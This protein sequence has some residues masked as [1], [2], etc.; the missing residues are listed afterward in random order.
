MEHIVRDLYRQNAQT[1]TPAEQEQV[2]PGMADLYAL[3]GRAHTEAAMQLVDHGVTC[4]ASSGRLLFRVASSSTPDSDTSYC[5]L[6]GRFC[7]TCARQP[8]AGVGGAPCIHITA[9]L[10]AAAQSKCLV[11]EVPAEELASALFTIT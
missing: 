3:L 4:L 10:V 11:E 1:Q 9:V 6:P 8:G 7:S 2:A 5:L